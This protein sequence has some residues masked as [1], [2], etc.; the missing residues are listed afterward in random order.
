MTIEYSQYFV[1]HVV[2]K[3]FDLAEPIP[4]LDDGEEDK[5]KVGGTRHHIDD[6]D[7]DE[8]GGGGG[9]SGGVGVGGAG[10]IGKI[11]QSPATLVI[12]KLTN[13]EEEIVEPTLVLTPNDPKDP[14]PPFPQ[15]LAQPKS[16]P[17]PTFYF[18]DQLKQVSI[19][20]PL[21][22]AIKDI[23]I[24]SKVLRE[25]CLKKVG[26]KKKDPTIVHALGKLA[27][28]MLGNV[29]MPKYLDPGSPI[30]SIMINGVMIQNALIDLGATINVMTKEIVQILNLAHIRPTH[31]ILQLADSFTV[32]PYGIIE[33]IVVTLE[34][35][36]YPT[37]FMILSP[38]TT[39]GG[40]LVIL[41]RPWLAT[42]DAYI[43]CRSRNM[44]ILNGDSTK[45]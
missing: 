36:E 28:T 33:D 40:Y 29:I 18:L 4:T 31:T 3:L 6:D 19:K 41:G 10:G 27:N 37:D 5:P 42:V 9:R 26:W 38:K 20:F 16:V 7:N 21:F 11:L 44:T 34:S 25:A 8:E 14:D 2:P 12:T 1:A 32:K 22:Q 43:G 30:V 15:I 17:E 13:K 39:L 35:W 24:Y 23:P 45:N